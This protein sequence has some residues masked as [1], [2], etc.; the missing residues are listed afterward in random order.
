MPPLCGEMKSPALGGGARLK[1]PKG[2]AARIRG[3]GCVDMKAGEKCRAACACL[4]GDPRPGVQDGLGGSQPP[5]NPS[6]LYSPRPLPPPNPGATEPAPQALSSHYRPRAGCRAGLRPMLRP[7]SMEPQAGRAQ[8]PPR[9]PFAPAWVLPRRC[10]GAGLP[11][12]AWQA[13]HYPL[14]GHEIPTPTF[15]ALPKRNPDP[16]LRPWTPRPCLRNLGQRGVRETWVS[17]HS[18]PAPGCAVGA[19][20]PAA[21][22]LPGGAGAPHPPNPGPQIPPGLRSRATRPWLREFLRAG[23]GRAAQV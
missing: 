20:L 16:C 3:G 15:R 12:T 8:C 2:G 21:L 11:G 1:S 14:G 19:S 17:R 9:S 18:Q 4:R 7:Q 10:A 13:I 22:E 6:A 5:G 23:E